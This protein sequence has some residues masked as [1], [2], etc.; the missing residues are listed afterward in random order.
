MDW[1]IAAIKKCTK[2]KGRSRRKE[3]WY[4]V[5][6]NLIIVVGLNFLQTF[7]SLQGAGFDS[8]G[9]SLLWA[10]ISSS[11]QIIYSFYMLLAITTLF[12]VSVRR[13]HDTGR[14]G[15]WFL[16]FFVP[17]ANFVLLFFYTQ[18]S[19]PGRN[20]YGKNPKEINS[21]H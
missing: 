17:L 1:Y 19:K 10:S 3:Y 5:L 11:L 8:T 13:L 16:L 12:S 6:I 15:W 4:F 7:V 9:V 2:L 14:S 21:S 18:N 20:Q